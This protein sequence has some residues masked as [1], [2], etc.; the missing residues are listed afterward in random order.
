MTASENKHYVFKNV[1]NP[2]YVTGTTEDG[3]CLTGH[4]LYKESCSCSYR[5]QALKR[6][7]S[8]RTKLY[9]KVFTQADIDA[10]VARRTPAQAVGP[11]LLRTSAYFPTDKATGKKTKVFP[12]HYSME[13][14]IPD[15]WSDWFVGGPS[16]PVQTAGGLPVGVGENF[17][18]DT[19]PYWNNAHH[20]IPKGTLKS[21][22]EER[23]QDTN[24]EVRT[25]IVDSLLEAKYNINH[26]KNMILLPQDKEVG[27]LYGLPRH[28][29]LEDDTIVVDE[30]C[31]KFNHVQYNQKVEKRLFDIINDYIQTCD[32]A[33]NPKCETKEVKLAKQKLEEL[34]RDCFIEITRAAAGEAISSIKHIRFHARAAAWGGGLPY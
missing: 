25:L 32:P 26:Y 23:T 13:L 4:E 12:G 3:G 30:E 2:H 14:G 22:I 31:P 33:A 28:L 8:H 9:D 17:I 10:V 19:A 21:V 20:M 11:G 1:A 15:D 27:L 6:S 34:S 7:R 5:W 24:P 29:V 16:R 18:R